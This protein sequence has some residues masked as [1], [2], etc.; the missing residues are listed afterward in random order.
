MFQTAYIVGSVLY[1]P[2]PRGKLCPSSTTA[3]TA[4]KT[5]RRCSSGP[6][7]AGGP[8]RSPVLLR[9]VIRRVIQ[10]WHRLCQPQRPARVAPV[11]LDEDPATAARAAG[12]AKGPS[13]GSRVFFFFSSSFLGGL[14]RR[15]RYRPDAKVLRHCLRFHCHG[16]T[17]TWYLIRNRVGRGLGKVP[18]AKALL[19]HGRATAE[20]MVP[21]WLN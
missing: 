16:D 6:G 15:R 5:R 14:L 18:C 7:S 10:V 11:E 9:R 17:R 4:L 19:S 1:A 3:R 13:R 8:C 2:Y 20:G 12:V 21:C